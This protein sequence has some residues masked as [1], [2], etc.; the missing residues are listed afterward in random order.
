MA[1]PT[2]FYI[3]PAG[4]LLQQLSNLGIPLAGGLL[5]IY[6]AGSVNTLQTTYT[7]ST[8]TTQNANPMILNSAGRL[9]ASNAP[10]SI[11][12]PGN[13]P[14]KMVLTDV[15]GNL[16]AGGVCMDNLYGINDPIG[17]LQSLANP[18][19]GFG[20]DLV[21]NAVRSY[22]VLASVRAA[23]VPVL[24]GAQTLVIDVEGGVLVND[25]NGGIFY[26]SATSTAVDDGSNVIKPNAITSANPGRYLRQANLFGST[27]TF[28]VNIT[29]AVTAPTMNITWVKNGSLVTI[30]MQGTAALTSNSTAFGA[31]GFLPALQGPTA[32]AVSPLFAAS[33]NSANGVAANVQ[34]PAVGGGTSMI[35]TINNATSLWTAAG[36][37]SLS[38]GAFTYVLH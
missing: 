21:A 28:L 7:D 14:H 10:A 12:V 23:N 25:G 18:V 2:V 35:F 13:T 15:T 38:A 33:D 32:S 36:S 26:W 5:Y 24:T 17:I 27:G 1:N 4:V 8:G 6:V 30:N 3:S 29:G 19:S 22:D 20:A 9:A 11:W 34:I 37:K 31:T 16:L